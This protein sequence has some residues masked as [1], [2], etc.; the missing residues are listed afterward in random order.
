[1][2]AE[3][4]I[5]IAILILIPVYFVCGFRYDFIDLVPDRELDRSP[6]PSDSNSQ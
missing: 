4:S 6:E 2:S 5:L 1:M 3:L